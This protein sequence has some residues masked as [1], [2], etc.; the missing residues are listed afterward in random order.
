MH[1]RAKNTSR[2][3]VKVWKKIIHANGNDKKV[4]VAILTDRIDFKK[5]TTKGKGWHYIK[6][7]IQ[8]ITPSNKY[9]PNINT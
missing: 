7:T 3:K 2:L 4:R 8:G 5:A 9:T 6:E 1:F